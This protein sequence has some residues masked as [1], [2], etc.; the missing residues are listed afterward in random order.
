MKVNGWQA[1]DFFLLL[2]PYIKLRP[3]IAVSA[4]LFSDV[5]NSWNE[6]RLIL[7]IHVP[8]WGAVEFGAVEF[9][10]RHEFFHQR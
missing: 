1:V 2:C 4:V 3:L 5:G 8:E 9:P 7:P 6:I 10:I